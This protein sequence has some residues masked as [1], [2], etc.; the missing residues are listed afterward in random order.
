MEGM[1]AAGQQLSPDVHAGIATAALTA[2]AA[3]Q[4]ANQYGGMPYAPSYM[5]RMADAQSSQ[6]PPPRPQYGHSP[7]SAAAT[8]A[9]YLLQPPH[10]MQQLAEARRLQVSTEHSRRPP[11]MLAPLQPAPAVLPEQQLEQQPEQ[12]PAPYEAGPS[13]LAVLPQEPMTVCPPAA[14]E[15]PQQPVLE[16]EALGVPLQHN[17]SAT[18]A[19][20]PPPPADHVE[21]PA[22]V[23]W[24]EPA[25]D[26]APIPM[27]ESAP[28]PLAAPASPPQ[29]RPAAAAARSATAATAS[30]S[31]SRSVPEA[32][33]VALGG[34]TDA[35]A[36]ALRLAE[37]EAEISALRVEVAVANEK[38][39]SYKALAAAKD[40]IIAT[41][42]K[43][44]T[45]W[46]KYA[47]EALAK[48]GASAAP[49]KEEKK[50]KDSKKK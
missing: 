16:H 44:T 12:Q 17:M 42:K 5:G 30:A 38:A 47:S 18:W 50:S 43:Q 45:E 27:A 31:A 8:Q 49:A 10:I 24:E 19:E 11:A 13:Q 25:A 23:S 1:S 28:P 48:V 26:I 2:A 33:A 35:K 3:M 20:E 4:H 40:E 15:L 22:S 39:E 46:R 21:M 34:F 9:M 14:E 7:A 32:D 37:A 29:T 36:L 41:A 6:Q